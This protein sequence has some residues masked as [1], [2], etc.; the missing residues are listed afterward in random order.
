MQHETQD[1]VVAWADEAFPRFTA[2]ILAARMHE[3]A[4]GL[5]MEAANAK[6]VVEHVLLDCA[7][8]AVLL[9]RVA[10][11][12]EIKLDL[13]DRGMHS[14]ERISRGQH[15]PSVLIA[16]D[17][18]RRCLPLVEA[19][20]TADDFPHFPSKLDSSVLFATEAADH[21]ECLC[22]KFGS[23]LQDAVDAR[24]RILRGIYPVKNDE[25]AQEELAHG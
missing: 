10:G 15:R 11:R 20:S 3:E 2:V 18:A 8:V 4:A 17:V 25:G 1:T 23:T 5:L 13:R 9:L 6:P 22:R 16:V 24:M 12:L 19:C 14:G 7:D 21:L